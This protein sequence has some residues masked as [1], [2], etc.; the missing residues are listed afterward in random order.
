MAESNRVQGFDAHRSTVVPWLRTTGIAGHI[1]GLPTVLPKEEYEP[2]LHLIVHTLEIALREAHSWC[3]DGPECRLTWPCQVVLGR[4]QAS[5]VETLG[6]TRPF[7]PRKDPGSLK[8]YFALAKRLLAY[9]HRVA[10]SSDDHFTAE[11]ENEAR[12]PENV[13]EMTSQQ[14][15]LWRRI[16]HTARRQV[17]EINKADNKAPPTGPEDELKERIVEV[18]MLLICHDTELQR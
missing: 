3:F 10:A 15:Q 6:R 13:M 17:A 9:V 4:F 8:K 12:R 1:H 14:L 16:S 2:I 18:L 7:E 5:E 11:D